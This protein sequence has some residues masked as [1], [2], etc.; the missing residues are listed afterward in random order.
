MYVPFIILEKMA[1]L[2]HLEIQQLAH[3]LWCVM[4]VSHPFF[5]GTA[6]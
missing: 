3:E 4:A 2:D 1:E 6:E 5:K